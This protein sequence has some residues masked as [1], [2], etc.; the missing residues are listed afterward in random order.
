MIRQREGEKWGVGQT[1]KKKTPENNMSA[2]GENRASLGIYNVLLAISADA[3]LA[4]EVRSDRL[5]MHKRKR[6]ITL[7]PLRRARRTTSATL[8]SQIWSFF[9]GR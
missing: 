1:I 4:K 3:F 6:S 7:L 8:V 9:W 2:P 5:P